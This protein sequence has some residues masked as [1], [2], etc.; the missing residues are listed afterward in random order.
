MGGRLSCRSPNLQNQPVDGIYPVRSAFVAPRGRR[1]V[2]ADYAQLELRVVAHLANCSAMID[3]LNSGGDLHSQTAYH[4]FS[5]VRDAVD[6]GKVRLDETSANA[7]VS[8]HGSIKQSFPEE[9][10]R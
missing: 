4:M 2:V 6:S 7:G 9:R 10:R 1:L 8:G 5:H 3:V